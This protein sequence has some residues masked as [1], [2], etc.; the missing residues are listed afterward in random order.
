[1]LNLSRA[2]KG[3][4]FTF[5]YPCGDQKTT[6]HP[7][8]GIIPGGLYKLDVFGA[9][10]GR[11][12]DEKGGHGGYSTG[13]LKLFYPT[14]IYLY[15]GARGI[16]SAT[17]FNA[18]TST[19]FN[20]GGSGRQ[21][22]DR[23]YMASSGG[24]SSDIRIRSDDIYHRLIVAGGG[25]GT[26]LY[27][28]TYGAGG[29]GGGKEGLK[30]TDIIVNGRAGSGA[31]Q[32]SGTLLYGANRT[33]YDGCGGGGGLFGGKSGYSYNN[34]GGGGSGFVHNKDSF[35]IANK[36]GIVLSKNY[37]LDNAS[38]STS[39]HIGDG[40]I[41]ITVLSILLHETRCINE[42]IKSLYF[43]IFLFSS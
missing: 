21:S 12:F 37:Y 30:G 31:T 25:G 17:S 11:A 15:V 33:D 6:C 27:N 10:G 8:A 5:E 3:S 26:G 14:R 38:T 39:D 22:R 9:E 13:I 35:E 16:S 36:A 34:P 42:I 40:K 1:M 2:K 4:V 19:A 41:V 28:S 24:G 18:N 20:G 29:D 32:S 7:Y 43:I 23:N